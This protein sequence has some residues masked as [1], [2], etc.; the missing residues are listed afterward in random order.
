MY[1]DVFSIFLFSLLRLTTL[2]AIYLVLDWILD[3]NVLSNSLIEWIL[4][5]GFLFI[6]FFEASKVSAKAN[7]VVEIYKKQVEDGKIERP[8]WM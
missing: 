1:K 4:L 8:W 5:I 2:L 7:R 3:F 6:V